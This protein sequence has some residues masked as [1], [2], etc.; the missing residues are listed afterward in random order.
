MRPIARLGSVCYARALYLPVM[1]PPNDKP[2]TISPAM[3]QPNDGTAPPEFHETDAMTVWPTIAATR[4]GR[5]VGRL[6]AI[7]IGL[8]S[9]FSL[10]TGF[11]VLTLPISLTVFAW[12][13]LPIV[14]RRYTLTDRR[15]VIRK[16]L[17]A[18]E[19]HSVGLDQF[20]TIEVK[21]LPGQS[22]HRSG[23]LAFQR[24]GTEVLRLRGV[25]RPEV[26][27]QVCLKVQDALISVRKVVRQQEAVR[28]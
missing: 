14:C 22:W 20:D 21:V 15:I 6:A 13:L 18:V 12:Q 4:L 24:E 7:R 17:T 28:Q 1:N 19:G 2:C 25:S 8:G 23:D 5:L 27:R 11:A 10:G 3:S 9:F 16:G 26:F